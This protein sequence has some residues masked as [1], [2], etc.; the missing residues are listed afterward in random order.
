MIFAWT[1][2]LPAAIESLPP[3]HRE[4]VKYAVNQPGKR[5]LSN[6]HAYETWGLNRVDFNGELECAY[7]AIRLY[8]RRHGITAAAD[9]DHG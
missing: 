9:L 2:I 8:L 5:R 1:D 3:L 6:K 4:I 7:G